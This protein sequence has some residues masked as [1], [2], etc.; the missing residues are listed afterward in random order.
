MLSSNGDMEVSLFSP[1]KKSIFVI[2]LDRIGQK[3]I[4]MLTREHSQVPERFSVGT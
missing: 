3:F 4:S 2:R 1:F